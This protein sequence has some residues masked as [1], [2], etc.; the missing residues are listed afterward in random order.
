MHGHAVMLH[1]LV[2]EIGPAQLH[3]RMQGAGSRAAMQGVAG[4][5]A[6]LADFA[7][8]DSEASLRFDALDG[9]AGVS[10]PRTWAGV[11]CHMSLS[12]PAKTAPAPCTDYI[13]VH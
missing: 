2:Q 5:S 9:T 3:L 8:F 10:G 11:R 13:M 12:A 6:Q 1:A 7:P 4:H